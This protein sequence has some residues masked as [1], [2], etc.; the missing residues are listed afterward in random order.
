MVFISV[1]IALWPPLRKE[2]ITRLAV[3]FLCELFIRYFSSFLGFKGI[4]LVLILQFSGLSL[5][6]P[7][8]NGITTELN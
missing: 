7:I 5:Y 4:I 2:L 8:N 1:M 6:V 3:S